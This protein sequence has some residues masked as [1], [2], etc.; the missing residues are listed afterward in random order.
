MLGLRLFGFI[1]FVVF[2]VT[3]LRLD[4]ELALVML[5][6]YTL[7]EEYKDIIPLIMIGERYVEMN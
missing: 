2:C 7:Y 6:C 5:R 3:L 4:E 1:V